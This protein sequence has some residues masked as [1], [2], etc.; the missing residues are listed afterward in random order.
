MSSAF[1]YRLMMS[2]FSF[3]ITPQL[4]LGPCQGCFRVQPFLHPGS[5]TPYFPHF[6]GTEKE[7]VNIAVNGRTCHFFHRLFLKY[8]FFQPFKGFHHFMMRKGQI[9]ANPMGHMV[10]GPLPPEDSH[11]HA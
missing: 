8:I 10:N 7:T 11:F 3:G 9:H 5:V 4:P 6:I 1:A 2:A